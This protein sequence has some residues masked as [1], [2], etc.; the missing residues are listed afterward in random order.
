MSGAVDQEATW[1]VCLLGARMHY[2]VPRILAQ[3]GRLECFFTDLCATSGWPRWLR[4]LPPALRPAG[5]RKILA[6]NPV[7]VPSERITAFNNFGMQYAR[8]R[9]SARNA[10]EIAQ[11]SNWANHHFGQ[12]VCDTDWGR[13]GGVFTFNGAGLEIL[14]RA[15]REGLRTVMEQTIA[16][17]AIEQKLVSAEQQ[18][19]PDWEQS[20][21]NESLAEFSRRE[22]AEWPLSDLILCGSEF[23]REGIRQ[24]GGPVEKCVVVPY[25]VDVAEANTESGKWKAEKETAHHPGPLSNAER[26]TNRPLRVLTV[27]AVGLRKGSP[28]I[29]EAAKLLKGK[30]VFRMVG[31]IVVTHEAEVRLGEFVELAGA[32]PRGEIARH[33]AWADVFL[34]PSL[35]EGSATVTY[36]ALAYGL[37]VI[38]TPNTGSVV[39]DGVEGFVVPARDAIAIAGRIERLAQDG[40]LRFRMAQNARSRAAE[41]TVEEYGLRLLS[42][43][44][45]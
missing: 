6:R 23:V 43:L 37:P 20:E 9:K 31:G 15:R 36:E 4:I 25:G 35:C 22:Q 8:R 40:A 29:L 44:A 10:S 2:A 42:A 11:T 13:A 16:P 24:C 41:F 26:K 34:L 45:A 19:H 12:L 3:A 30:A 27:G 14:E 18:L 7:G 17:S 21:R 28:Y 33:F 38:C 5:L 1:L 39:R 32:V